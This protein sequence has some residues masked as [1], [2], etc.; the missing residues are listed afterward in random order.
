MATQRVKR[1]AAKRK[2]TTRSRKRVRRVARKE[3]AVAEKAA[4]PR[5][6]VMTN[7]P[8]RTLARLK[9]VANSAGVSVND[10]INVILALAFE[11]GGAEAE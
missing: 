11:K 5:T 8:K 2:A 7:M 9:G 1:K 6:F 3:P 4:A 10:A